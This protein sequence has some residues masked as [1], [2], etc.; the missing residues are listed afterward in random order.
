MSETKNT[1]PMTDFDPNIKQINGPVNVARLEGKVHGIKKVVYLF[2]DY[3]ADLYN[4]TECTNIFKQDVDE[5]FA[6]TFYDLNKLDKQF[7]FFLELRPAQQLYTK[8]ELRNIPMVYRDKYIGQVLK[9]FKK[10][11]KYD[12]EKNKVDIPDIFKNVRLHYLDIRDYLK[13]YFIQRVDNLIAAAQRIEHYGASVDLLQILIDNIT[14]ISKDMVQFIDIV[15]KSIEYPKEK[16]AIIKE[17]DPY[18]IDTTAIQQLIYKVKYRYNHDDIKDKLNKLFADIM[19]ELENYVKFLDGVVSDFNKY[20][21]VLNETY[22]WLIKDDRYADYYTYGPSGYDLRTIKKNIV[23]RIDTLNDYFTYIFAKLTDIYL[24]R[25][26]LDKDYI[27]NAITYSGEFH[28]VHYIYLLIK[29]FDFKIT[30]IVYA[31]IEPLDDLNKKLKESSFEDAIGIIYKP[32]LYQCSDITNF[33]D[34]FA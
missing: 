32:R 26:I 18:S 29:H 15:N 8:K 24:L 11:F 33:P 19:L 1:D 25:R 17:N 14:S 28:A 34:N 23:D 21:D 7:D 13:Y 2:M 22:G 31:A 30:H 4:Q 10:I 9:F 20:K 12:E 3:H 6:K 16:T 5:Y 27:T